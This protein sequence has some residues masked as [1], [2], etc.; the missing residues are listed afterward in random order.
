MVTLQD[1][2]GLSPRLALDGCPLFC[3]I[4]Y[5]SY[6]LSWACC[7]DGTA[8]GTKLMAPLS[9]DGD[10]PMTRRSGSRKIYFYAKGPQSLSAL[11]VTDGS[12]SGTRLIKAEESSSSNAVLVN[13][14]IIFT[15]DDLKF[16]NEL[17]VLDPGATAQVLGLGC[18]PR[19]IAPTLQG[20]DPVLGGN[21]RLDGNNARSSAGLLLISTRA[22]PSIALRAGCRI[23]LALP[24]LTVLA[25]FPVTNGKWSLPLFIPNQKSLLGLQVAVQSFHPNSSSALGFD[26]SNGLLLSLGN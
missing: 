25:S 21:M 23:F 1:K 13:G 6:E 4:I 19:G 10:R 3:V 22:L 2:S 18:T 15:A 24:N 8:A 20:S 9:P 14:R 7:S 17:W 11:W 26:L 16:G 12:S 5:S